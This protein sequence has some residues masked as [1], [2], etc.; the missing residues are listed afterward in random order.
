MHAAG[1]KPKAHNAPDGV[2]SIL[3]INETFPRISSGSDSLLIQVLRSLRELG[4]RVT[5]VARDITHRESSKELLAELGVRV[6][7]GDVARLRDLGSE[8]SSCSWRFEE[9]LAEGK[10]GLALLTQSFGRGISVAEHYLDEIRRRSP[11]THIAI[12][13]ERLY[14][15]EAEKRA[16]RTGKF[17]HYENAADL[18]QREREAFRRADL[19][20]VAKACD[21][22]L[23]RGNEPGLTVEFVSGGE[24]SCLANAL[25][26]VVAR[27]Q[28]LSPKAAAP[29]PFSIALVDAIYRRL[30]ETASGK[31]RVYARLDFY[32]Q[33]AEQLLRQGQ[34]GLAREQ[35]RH[36]FGWLGDSIQLAPA[37]AQPLALLKRCYLQFGDQG[38][39]ARC[40]EQAR[41]CFAD[42]STHPPSPS[43]SSLRKSI[44]P[45]KSAAE[46]L[47]SLIVPTYNRL[48]I[49]K[50]C[51][52]ALE[53]Q[54]ISA[55]QFEVIVIDD[56]SSDGTEEAMRRYHPDFGFQYLRQANSG[57]GAARRHGVE[58]ARGE[59]LLLMNDDTICDANLLEQH[60][61]AHNQYSPG[62]WA[63]LGAFEYPA[64]ARQRALSH[65][66]STNPFMFPQV[67]MA[68]GCPYGYS[69][70]IT[71]NLSIPRQAVMEAGSFDSTFK[72]SEDT[73]LGI[74]LFEMGY[75]VIYHP[76]AHAWHD[77]LPYRAA[78]LI[79]RARVYG[80][81]YF[82][83][84]RKHPRVLRE[85]AMPIALDAMDPGN[86]QRIRAYLD[87]QRKQVEGA[88][89][90]LERW[91]AVEF[92]PLLARPKEAAQILGLFQQ[93]VP[94]I[95]WFYL[96]ESMLETM[97]KELGL[98]EA[99]SPEQ[100]ALRAAQV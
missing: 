91:D 72:L 9:V 30:L 60:L 65:F 15:L 61:R 75:G 68:E 45:G 63:I 86:A 33:F 97:S 31:Q 73:E 84:F 29:G 52:A 95:H 13:A 24:E 76:G 35:L 85:W 22:E 2:Q 92:E 1:P 96:F 25:A 7:A 27:G 47:I 28:F 56:G 81:D 53:A 55:R 42:L 71:C 69:H 82:Y 48:S 23:L 17:E 43:P 40:A 8:L 80:A 83:M 21:A 79:R 34:P 64:V 46:P 36:I 90:A 78:N 88:V 50:N 66:L 19:V 100:M 49:L 11:T 18:A 44:T 89:A 16:A 41:L 4:H 39:A 14:G 54:T 32:M 57:T 26:D 93:A 5:L 59:Y 62:R 38:A 67:E 94:A 99:D 51:L 20:F 70:F 77:H 6:Y 87:P 10:F 37:L 98:A 58:Q 74:R 12:L 3:V